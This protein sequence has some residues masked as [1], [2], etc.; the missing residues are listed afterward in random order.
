VDVTVQANF[1]DVVCQKMGGGDCEQGKKNCAANFT[2]DANAALKCT[3]CVSGASCTAGSIKIGFTVTA[4]PVEGSTATVPS[5]QLVSTLQ[6]RLTEPASPLNQGALAKLVDGGFTK[7][8]VTSV[9]VIATTTTPRPV[10]SGA[11]GVTGVSVVA[12]FSFLAAM[13]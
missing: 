8:N 2:V 11:E 12:L 3:G 1:T 4:A 7:A 5:N 13:L 6:T 9:L 10:A